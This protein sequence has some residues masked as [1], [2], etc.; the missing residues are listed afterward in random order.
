[1]KS[2]ETLPRDAVA[3]ILN[4]F[5]LEGNSIDTTKRQSC[6][7]LSWVLAFLVSGLLYAALVALAQT[8]EATESSDDDDEENS[9]CEAWGRP[10]FIEP[11]EGSKLSIEVQCI[12]GD[13]YLARIN[14]AGPN[15]NPDLLRRYLRQEPYKFGTMSGAE[16]RAVMEEA[17]RLWPQSQYAHAGLAFA[18]LGGRGAADVESTPA[19]KRRAAREC[20]LALVFSGA[21]DIF[22]SSR[23][24]SDYLASR[25][26]GATPGATSLLLRLAV[27]IARQVLSIAVS[28]PMRSSHSRSPAGG[29][30]QAVRM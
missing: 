12:I 22:V 11:I 27:L 9:V 26:A 19:E 29:T 16:Y 1:M 3:Y 20:P 23:V 6:P 30:R 18:L 24:T 10:R 2:G 8:T 4:R 5:L 13:T 17:V 25:R 14:P 21:A 7:G 28:N 15:E